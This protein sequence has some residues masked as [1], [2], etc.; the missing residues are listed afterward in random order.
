MSRI[1][2][3]LD[4]VEDLKRLTQ[5]MEELANAMQENEPSP[6]DKAPSDSSQKKDNPVTADIEQVRNVLAEKYESG[7]RDAVRQLIRKFGG[8]KLTDID[9]SKYRQILKEA[10]NL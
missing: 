6:N 5:S 10:A 9:P 4:V 1:K 8:A 3:V 2:L 7:K